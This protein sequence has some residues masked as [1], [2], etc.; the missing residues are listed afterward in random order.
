MP[1]NEILEELKKLTKIVTVANG[2]VITK[3]IEKIATT[4]NRKKIWVFN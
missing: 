3:E 2:S 1:K 4:D